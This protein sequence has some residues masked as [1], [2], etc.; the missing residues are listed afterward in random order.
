MNTYFGSKV[1]TEDGV[2]LNNEMD[3]FSSPN[4][5]NSYGLRP[6]ESNYISPGKRPLSSTCPV[7]A[8][9][10]GSNKNTLGTVSTRVE[11]TDSKRILRIKPF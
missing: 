9:K 3:D 5:T 6:S 2:I 8:V 1:V 7:V 10:V 4:I 11:N